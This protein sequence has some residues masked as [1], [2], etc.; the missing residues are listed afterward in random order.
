MPPNL[1]TTVAMKS[2]FVLRQ[3]VD[4]GGPG[5]GS[6]RLADLSV[7][8]SAAFCGLT[9][10]FHCARRPRSTANPPASNVSATT[11]EAGSIS[12]A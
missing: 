11:M 10:Q 12:G 3:W 7:N 4:A 9:D 6:N 1:P 2:G 8:R 5:S